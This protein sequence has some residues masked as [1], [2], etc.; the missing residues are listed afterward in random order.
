VI[1]S[2]T[3]NAQACETFVS[4]NG[5]SGY[6]IV[7]GGN[8]HTCNQ[9]H[10]GSQATGALT[11]KN[12]GK[13]TTI[14]GADIGA[15]TGSNGAAKIDGTN[16]SWTI[17]GGSSGTLYVAGIG[18]AGGTGLL[19]VTN[20]GIVFVG[21]VHVYAPG[22]LAGNGTVSAPNGTTIEGTLTPTVGQLA[23]S[24]DLTFHTTPGSTSTLECNVTPAS[25]DNVSVSGSATLT[26]KISVTMTGTTFTAGSTYTLLHANGGLN[27]TSFVTVSIKG[28]SGDCFT[29]LITYPS[30]NKD[31]NL[32]LSPCN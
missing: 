14:S 13:V 32:Y 12:A 24:G 8:L 28:G 1:S 5:G 18:A 4:Y 20:G 21:S 6:L 26:G 19:T 29:P 11:I 2:T 30:N 16:S 7:D 31:V 9:L 23:V 10:V 25:A 22:T 3:Q 27:N 17:A 15:S